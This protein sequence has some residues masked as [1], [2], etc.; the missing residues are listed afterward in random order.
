MT[1]T[2]TYWRRTEYS[3]KKKCACGAE[4]ANNSSTCHP[5]YTRDRKQKAV[6]RYNAK[7]NGCSLQDAKDSDCLTTD[8]RMA[9]I[10]IAC[11]KLLAK[12]G[13]QSAN[14]FR[15]AIAEIGAGGKPQIINGCFV[16]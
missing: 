10:N 4:I 13:V 2:E 9:K 14:Y 8:E 11:D 6:D 15:S 5:C 7:K 3:Q 12:I 16:K 1:P